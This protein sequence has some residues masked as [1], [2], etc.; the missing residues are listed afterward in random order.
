MEIRVTLPFTVTEHEGIGTLTWNDGKTRPATDEE[1]QLATALCAAEDDCVARLA[2]RE[3]ELFSAAEARVEAAEASAL[4]MMKERDAA[5]RLHNITSNDL[6]KTEIILADVLGALTSARDTLAEMRGAL[7][8]ALAL[9]RV[10]AERPTNSYPAWLERAQTW[11]AQAQT[12]LENS[13]AES[14]VTSVSAE[15]CTPP[16]GRAQMDYMLRVPPT[17]Q[18]AREAVAWTFEMGEAEYQV[19]IET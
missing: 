11:Q 18:T 4:A 19:A 14:P 3:R 6:G 9:I 2:E 13:A 17:M 7:I 8:E 10:G 16:G 5:V 15:G 12:L 1:T